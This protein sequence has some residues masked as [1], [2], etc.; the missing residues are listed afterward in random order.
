M[1]GSQISSIAI[2][3]DE[4]SRLVDHLMMMCVY[5]KI[6]TTTYNTSRILVVVCVFLEN[7]NFIIKENN[8]EKNLNF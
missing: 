4:N 6:V 8:I 7:L 2:R 5:L 1:Y 3:R